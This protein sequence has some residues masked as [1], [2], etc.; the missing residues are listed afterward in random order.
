METGG[1]GKI[2]MKH[3]FLFC[4]HRFCDAAVA[5]PAVHVAAPRILMRTV[6]VQ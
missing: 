3:F 1:C 2:I 4:K 5:K 6:V